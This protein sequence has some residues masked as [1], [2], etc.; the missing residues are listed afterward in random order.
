MLLLGGGSAIV[1]VKNRLWTGEFSVGSSPAGDRHVRWH[2]S[3]G[4]WTTASDLLHLKVLIIIFFSNSFSFWSLR[5]CLCFI[6]RHSTL[7]PSPKLH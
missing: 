4:E 1:V 2:P 7:P 5:G 6:P 3:E